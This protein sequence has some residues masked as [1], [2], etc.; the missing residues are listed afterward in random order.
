MYMRNVII[1]IQP[2][3]DL[4]TTLPQYVF[5]ILQYVCIILLPVKFQKNTMYLLGWDATAEL[6]I[7]VWCNTTL[8]RH[9]HSPPRVN[10]TKVYV[11]V[12]GVHKFGGRKL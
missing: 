1:D 8:A 12:F 2:F 6:T 4:S 9:L 5:I 10:L 3:Y 11:F 7:L